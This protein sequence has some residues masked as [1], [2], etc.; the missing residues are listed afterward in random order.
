MNI[1]E[2]PDHLLKCRESHRRREKWDAIFSAQN[3]DERLEEAIEILKSYNS[4]EA[5]GEF[6]DIYIGNL[7]KNVTTLWEIRAIVNNH[8]GERK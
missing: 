3:E 6:L 4:T 1:E 5:I 2:I 7:Q 8:Y